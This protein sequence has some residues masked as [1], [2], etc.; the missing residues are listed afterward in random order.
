VDLKAASS[1]NHSKISDLEKDEARA[2]HR[3]VIIRMQID[4]ANTRL[5][6]EESKRAAL[7]LNIN[8]GRKVSIWASQLK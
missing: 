2:Q 7:E 1:A 3:L 6:E 8:L 4:E 5:R